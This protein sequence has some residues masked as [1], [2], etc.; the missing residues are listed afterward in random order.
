MPLCRVFGGQHTHTHTRQ[1]AV[2][3]G[4]P[5]QGKREVICFICSPS[6]GGRT[7]DHRPWKYAFLAR[8][9]ASWSHPEHAPDDIVSLKDP[10]ML[11]HIAM[12]TDVRSASAATEAT[13]QTRDMRADGRH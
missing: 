11:G 6:A 1:R 4:C 8:V 10:T 12:S 3:D 13:N 5:E 9:A 7:S 2:E